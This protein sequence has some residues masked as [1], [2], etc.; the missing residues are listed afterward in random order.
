MG[1]QGY[2]APGHLGCCARVGGGP[3][4]LSMHKVLPHVVGSV[5]VHI[6][7]RT[8]GGEGGALDCWDGY[9]AGRLPQDLL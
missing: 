3:F 8:A 5:R 6:H 9:V 1:T 7:V 2:Y 4:A